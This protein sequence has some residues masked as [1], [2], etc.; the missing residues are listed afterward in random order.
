M[1]TKSE[2]KALHILAMVPDISARGFALKMWPESYMHT[3]HLACRN[4][5]QR[6][7]GAWLCAG[8]Y[9][10][11]LIKKGLVVKTRNGYQLSDDGKSAEQVHEP[12]QE[13]GA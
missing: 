2:K 1:I 9:L 10:G 11:K 6:G 3:N 7:K 13:S 12:E 8:S 4:G 5:V